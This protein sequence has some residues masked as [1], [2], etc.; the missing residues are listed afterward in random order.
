MAN[1]PVTIEQF[2]SLNLRDTPEEVGS[3]GAIG[4]LNVDLSLPNNLQ[5]RG[6]IIDLGGPASGATIDYLV[7]IVGGAGT[8]TLAGISPGV[9]DNITLS[10][11]VTN[12]DTW[13]A[14]AGTP[15]AKMGVSAGF[16]Q[17]GSQEQ[18]YVPSID[19]TSG[20]ALHKYQPFTNSVDTSPGSPQYVAANFN[21]TRLVQA[22]YFASADT[23]SAD[24]GTDSTLFFSDENEPDTYTDTNWL[25]LDAG[26]GEIFTGHVSWTDG[27]YTFKSTHAYYFY[28]ESALADGVVEFLYRRIS[29]PDPI[30][31]RPIGSAQ[32]VAPGPDGV[33]YIGATGLWRVNGASLPERIETPVDPIFDGTAGTLAPSTFDGMKLSWAGERMFLI[34]TAGPT[35]FMLVWDHKVNTWTMWHLAVQIE[36]SPVLLPAQIMGGSI[37]GQSDVL[38]FG[39]NGAHLF[40]QGAGIV[41]DA[42]ADIDWSYTSGKYPLAPTLRGVV[43]QNGFGESMVRYTDVWGSGVITVRTIAEGARAADVADVGGQ[44]TLGTAPDVARARYARSARGRRFQHVLS[45]VGIASVE[46]LDRWVRL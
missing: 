11:I 3:S 41:D 14:D 37:A 45:G 43:A 19:G 8:P 42:G 10:G 39:A 13:T 44:L 5:T 15:P 25:T 29:L 1:V 33:Y 16:A 28:G 36:S 26:D 6:G 4:L 38:W 32:L 24:N 27:H 46:R 40:Q 34:Y 20:V 35:Q 9:V 30:P 18:I 2:G 17:L 22:G 7:P 23:P 21:G 31:M 12:V